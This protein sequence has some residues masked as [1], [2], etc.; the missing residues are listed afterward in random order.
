LLWYIRLNFRGTEWDSAGTM[1]NEIMNNIASGPDFASRI[2]YELKRAE[3]YRVFLSLVV[4]N[5]GP[6][7]DLAENDVFEGETKRAKLLKNLRD[8]I[9]DSARKVDLTSDLGSVKIGLL[10][11]ETPRQGAEAATRRISEAL[12]RFCM[13]CFKKPVDY[14][15]PVE[16]SSFPD[17]AGARSIPSYLEEFAYT[18]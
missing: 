14:L 12:Y 6:I 7:L 17:A 9:R 13:D 18:G 1:R 11:P 8:V 3:R 5:V 4:F 2:D 10:L 15:V 16:I